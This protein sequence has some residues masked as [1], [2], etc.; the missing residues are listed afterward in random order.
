MTA[1]EKYAKLTADL[2]KSI[3]DAFVKYEHEADDGTCNFDSPTISLNGYSPKYL[4][5]AIK[6]AGAY[7]YKWR[8]WNSYV[9]CVGGG[10]AGRRTSIAEYIYE[11]MRS[12]GYKMGMYYQ[13]D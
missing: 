8:G 12:K 2:A 11:D 10:Q 13:I 6:N 4:E 3:K 1:K 9:I 5:Q 7:C